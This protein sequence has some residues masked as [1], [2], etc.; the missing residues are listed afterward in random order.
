MLARGVNLPKRTAAEIMTPNP[1]TCSPFSTILE[2]VLIFRDESC[3]AV[4]VVDSGKPVGIVTDRDVALALADIPDLPTHPV[5]EFMNTT[6]VTTPPDTALDVVLE[7]LGDDTNRRV[8]VV[9]SQDQLLGIIS[10][11]DVIRECA[12]SLFGRLVTEDVEELLPRS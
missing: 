9:D 5:S 1:R 6:L 8:L 10:W 4:P 11:A 12:G 3:G 7:K 2:A